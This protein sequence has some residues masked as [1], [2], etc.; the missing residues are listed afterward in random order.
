MDTNDFLDHLDLKRL[1]KRRFWYVL[2]F[3]LFVLSL[4][5]VQPLLFLAALFSLVIGFVPSWWYRHALCYLAI[6][7]Q[8]R[9]QRL[10]FGEQVVLSVT[11]EN[12][13]LLPLTWLVCEEQL[14][15]PLPIL[16][17]QDLQRE[18][19]G[20]IDN[21]GSIGAFQRITRH[22]RMQCLERGF[23]TFGP[24]TLSSS[25][26]F[27]WMKCQTTLPL[28]NTL[29]VYP[30]IASLEDLGLTPLHLFGERSTSRRLFEDPLRVIGARDYQLGDDLRRIHWKAT[31]RSGELHSKVYEYSNQHRVLFLLDTGDNAKAILEISREMLE[32]SIAVAAS[33][34]VYALDKGYTVGALTNCAC[35][36]SPELKETDH[37]VTQNEKRRREQFKAAKIAP[38]GV[39]VPF[40]RDH[41]QYER[42]L[43]TFS[44][45]VPFLTIS[46]EE[47]IERE[48]A[49]FPAGT[50]VILVSAI[51]AL[52]SATIE[53]LLDL[54]S[55]RIT[56]QCVITGDAERPTIAEA[57]NLPVYYVGGKEKWHALIQ[58]FTVEKK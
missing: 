46:M 10:F 56:I 9:P 40:A 37:I 23:Y 44:R 51:Q 7:Q 11:I 55:R 27:G 58:A 57:Y 15:P 42:L 45:L 22:Y 17:Q 49:L 31:A 33:L 1:R 20:Y 18:T 47:V 12:Q 52:T 3:A 19:V 32:F 8:V 26:P 5:A 50:E 35:L 30:L 53:R 41:R 54:R 43:T 21:S 2:A 29:L 28:Y 13:K 16:K 38:A 24:L 34:A 6:R 48:D 25:D 4:M 39:S 14:H 36:T